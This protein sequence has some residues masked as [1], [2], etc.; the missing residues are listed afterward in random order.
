[1][2]S[3]EYISLTPPS[4]QIFQNIDRSWNREVIYFLL[5]DRFSD[6]KERTI[7]HGGKMHGFQPEQLELVCGGKLEGIRKNLMYL[8]QLGITALWLSPIFG[9][10]PESYHGYAIQDFLNVD[11]RFGTLDELKQLIRE[12]HELDLKVILDIV[13][14]HTGNNWHYSEHKHPVYYRG[15][16]YDFGGWRF[17]DKPVP[18]ELRD[19]KC[20]RKQGQIS[21]WDKF[22]E[23]CEGDFFS[24]K[25]LLL[26]ESAEGL[27]VQ[28]VL[29]KI[30]SYWIKETDC[31]GFRIDTV[32]H[33]GMLPV[34]R[35][36]KGIRAYCASIGKKNF[37]L[38]GELTGGDA[39]LKSSLEGTKDTGG[40]FFKGPDSLLDFPLHFVLPEVIKGHV[41]VKL[42]K[43]RFKSREKYGLG[44]GGNELVTFLDN[45]D[46]IGTLV[47]KR[48]G[49]DSSEQEVVASLAILLFLPGIPCI[50]Y[51][52]EQHLKGR[53]RADSCIREPMFSSDGRFS[54]MDTRHWIY[55]QFARLCA[56]RNEV[57]IF[58]LPK[59]IFNRQFLSADCDIKIPGREKIIVFTRKS[60]D[61]QVIFVYNQQNIQKTAYVEIPRPLTQI[62][63]IYSLGNPRTEMVNSV[64][65]SNKFDLIKAVL[66]PGEL[67]II[68]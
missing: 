10:N 14:N 28:D 42:L 48:I 39:L 13:I 50:Y 6:G 4:D 38:F 30:Y 15:R 65:G 23:T 17:P 5:V 54:F 7:A 16:R 44:M 20:Y 33:A 22:P 47:K 29:L 35:F 66:A 26:D 21:N 62:N 59:L 9:N 24:L 57:R 34:S 27:S 46:Q 11:P 63:Y 58:D 8:K 32:K 41:P 2:E 60:E 68:K 18:L 53:G 36:C 49:A 51:G 40:Q 55:Q 12:A 25:K 1:M 31:D 37:I 64:P 3:I 56:I 52:T 43:K 67:V 45:H 19:E 61:E